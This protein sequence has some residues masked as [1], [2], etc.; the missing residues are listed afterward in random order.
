V[1]TALVTGA[2][3]GFGRATAL[4]LARAGWTVIAPVRR[5]EDA[6]S[7][8]AMTTP[9]GSLR[10][11]RADVTTA[12]DVLRLGNETRAITDRLDGLVNNA[13]TAYPGP[14]ELLP[15]DDLRAQ[16][17]V[18]VIGQLA[19]TQAVLP[20]VRQARGTIVNVSSIGGRRAMPML[21]AYS[22]SKFALEAMSDA[23]RIELAPFGVKVVVIEPGGSP[24]AIWRTSL[25]RASALGDRP[26]ADAY[27]PLIRVMR[28]TAETA[29]ETG[30]PPEEF[31]ALVHRILT[32]ARP[33]ARYP[34][35]PG[36]VRTIA[37][38]RL[39]PDRW[40][41]GLIRRKLKW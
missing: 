37:L 11:V 41:D 39:L 12:V 13:G 30:F 25:D 20:L 34:L 4:H 28:Q 27:A 2:S 5:E 35:G 38:L 7:L 33:R 3:S 1:P 18:N 29:S 21:G 10:V 40:L 6:A 14:L 36:V 19:V 16:F 8:G 31:A 17:E 22:A 15:V 9:A 24:T 26:R 32:M 23:L